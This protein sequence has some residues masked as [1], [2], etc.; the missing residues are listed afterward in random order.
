MPQLLSFVWSLLPVLRE[1][2][3]MRVPFEYQP[4]WQSEITLTPA[5]SRSTGR[6]GRKPAG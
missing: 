3:R 4:C 6:G 2:V 5:L 1:K